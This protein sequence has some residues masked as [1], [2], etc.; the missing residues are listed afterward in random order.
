MVEEEK[1]SLTK[2]L[3]NASTRRW[4]CRNVVIAQKTNL[5]KMILANHIWRDL[6]QRKEKKSTKPS[7]AL[8]N[9]FMNRENF[10]LVEILTRTRLSNI[11]KGCCQNT[12]SSR[13]FQWLQL[14]IVTTNVSDRFPFM[15][16][17]VILKLFVSWSQ[18]GGLGSVE[19]EG[20]KQAW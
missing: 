20:W 5:L 14:N 1:E 16:K 2:K 12:R 7:S 6:N 19:K 15:Y 11:R 18:K 13:I 3:S 4:N 17:N 10:S 8:P 9:V